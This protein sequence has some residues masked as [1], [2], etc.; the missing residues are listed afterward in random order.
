VLENRDE[1]R[2]LVERI[3]VPP[4]YAVDT[5]VPFF[6]AG[7]D[8]ARPGV[9]TSYI[10][11]TF[12]PQ[13]AGPHDGVVRLHT[14]DPAL[15]TVDVCVG[16]YAGGPVW[17]CDADEIDFGEVAVGVP[18]RR[19]VTCVN[20]GE[21]PSGHPMTELV[22]YSLSATNLDFRTSLRDPEQRTFG[23][24]EPFVVEVEARLSA[25]GSIAAAAMVVTNAGEGA[26]ERLRLRARGVT[27][28]PCVYVLDP[29][30]LAFAPGENVRALQVRNV[31]EA[32]CLVHDA[33]IE[34][35]AFSLETAVAAGTRV[36]PGESLQL[37]LRF[38]PDAAAGEE[39]AQLVLQIS[40]PA[41]PLV[42]VPLSAP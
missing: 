11:I 28:E 8:L 31:G 21:G 19:A 5:N 16:G 26:D 4:A 39:T 36:E 23:P 38:D 18:V 29:P 7:D 37:Q 2:N 3:D 34:A 1:E 42:E 14:S 12:T 10:P 20:V 32:A 40:D 9:P 30:S 25:A 15:P 35:R 13:Q 22:I 41:R 33:A 6:I 24:G 17:A 27:L